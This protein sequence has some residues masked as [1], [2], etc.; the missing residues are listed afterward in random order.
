MMGWRVFTHSVRM[1][2]RNFQEAMQIALVPGIIGIAL[3]V[4]L[5]TVTG[6]TDV[7]SGATAALDQSGEDAG[8]LSGF[9]LIALLVIWT[10]AFWIVVS[11]HRF[12]LLEEIPQGWLPKFRADRILAYFGLLVLLSLI[13]MIALVPAIFVLAGLYE[14]ASGVSFAIGVVWFIAVL[15]GLYR[16]SIMLPASAI[17]KPVKLAEA[18]GKTR[19]ITGTLIVLIAV[20]MGFQILVQI[21]FGLL[22]AI[23]VIGF[24]LVL[25]PSVLI[26]PLI[27]VSIL[28]TMYGVY[29]EGRSIE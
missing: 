13:A 3:L 20:S 1:V 12:V 11:W 14:V 22:M 9:G 5:A 10:I 4:G 24:A 2:L 29:V 21:V 17:G 25:I 19:G 15:L 26:L 23:P 28:T 7:L 16:L 18:W 6:A 8:D 27:N